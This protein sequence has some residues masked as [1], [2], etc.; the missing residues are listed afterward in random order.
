MMMLLNDGDRKLNI[1]IKDNRNI[2]DNSW[3]Y[4]DFTPIFRGSYSSVFNSRL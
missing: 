1:E 2:E 3:F 4:E